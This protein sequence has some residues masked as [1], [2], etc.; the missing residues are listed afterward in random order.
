[1]HLLCLKSYSS[2]SCDFFISRDEED[3][4]DEI[5]DVT[6]NKILIITQTPPSVMPRKHPSG[7][8][9]GDFLPRAKMTAELA[10]I[11]NDGLFYYEQDL[12]EESVKVCVYTFVTVALYLYT[13]NCIHVHLVLID[14][15]VHVLLLLIVMG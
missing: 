8:R 10:K 7:D 11:I 1:M 4:D 14:S 12:Y 5:D 15:I 2:L 13:G 6:L 3:S 9:T